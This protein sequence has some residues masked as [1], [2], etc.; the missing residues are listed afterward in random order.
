M[1]ANR[2][3]FSFRRHFTWRLRLRLTTPW[4]SKREDDVG[5][6]RSKNIMY[7][8]AC[9]IVILNGCI[10]QSMRIAWYTNLIPSRTPFGQDKGRR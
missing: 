5:I 8:G 1:N 4:F 10:E 9:S 3:A 6:Y 2:Q 7:D